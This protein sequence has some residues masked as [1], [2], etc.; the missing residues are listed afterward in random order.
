ML[1][2]LLDSSPSSTPTRLLRSQL[3]PTTIHIKLP[4]ALPIQHLMPEL[5]ATR[6]EVLQ[7]LDRAGSPITLREA[8]NLPPE[9]RT[10]PQ[11]TPLIFP[12][13]GTLELIFQSTVVYP[14]R[15]KEESC[16]RAQR[17]RRDLA[18]MRRQVRGAVSTVLLQT[19]FQDTP[20]ELL[21]QPWLL[22]LLPSLRLTSTVACLRSFQASLE[23]QVL[24]A[25]RSLWNQDL[26]IVGILR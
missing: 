25:F 19:T 15:I 12:T 7:E 10:S 1:L 11:R 22:Q 14:I 26:I 13:S 2:L 5:S 21:L 18:L 20:I 6:V 3:S 16:R 4:I 17:P 8:L 23:A 9:I 24:Q